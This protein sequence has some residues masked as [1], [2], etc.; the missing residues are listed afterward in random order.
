VDDAEVVV[1][2]RAAT[3]EALGYKVTA[4]T[5]ATRALADPYEFDVLVTDLSMPGLSGAELARRAREIRPGLPV[6][7]TSGYVRP[8]DGDVIR[9]AGDV[10]LLLKPNRVAE[11]GSTLHRLLAR[12]RSGG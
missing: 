12:Q 11:L 6:V 7:L 3:L 5:D 1:D 8:E 4:V 9:R 2:V 10:E